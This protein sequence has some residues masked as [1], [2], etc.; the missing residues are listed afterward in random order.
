VISKKVWYPRV[1]LE[2]KIGVPQ[3]TGNSEDFEAAE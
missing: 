3:E 1:S 2:A